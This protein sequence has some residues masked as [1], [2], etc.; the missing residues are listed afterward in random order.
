MAA[1]LSVQNV[2]PPWSNFD[3]DAIVRSFPQ[4]PFPAYV[5][6]ISLPNIPEQVDYNSMVQPW[7]AETDVLF[8]L[9]GSDFGEDSVFG[10]QYF[11]PPPNNLHAQ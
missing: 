4:T 6:E 11:R 9:M 7:D 2:T 5:P 3:L 10:N 8:G 1:S